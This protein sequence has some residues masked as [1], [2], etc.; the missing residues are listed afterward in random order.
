MRVALFVAA[1]KVTPPAAIVYRKLR[2][3]SSAGVAASVGVIVKVESDPTKLVAL[4]TVYTVESPYS[5]PQQMIN[6]KI[7]NLLTSMAIGDE[8]SMYE[9]AVNNSYGT[10]LWNILTSLG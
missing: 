1:A 9:G 5:D 6:D 2:T 7:Q 10:N 8:K 3:A 4:L